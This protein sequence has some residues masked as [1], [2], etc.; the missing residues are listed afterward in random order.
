[1]EEISH[2]GGKSRFVIGY[3]NAFSSKKARLMEHLRDCPICGADLDWWFA[4]YQKGEQLSNE[5]VLPTGIEDRAQFLVALDQW[6]RQRKDVFEHDITRTL[7]YFEGSDGRVALVSI[8]DSLRAV[9]QGP[10]MPW[11]EAPHLWRAVDKLAQA[12]GD[13]TFQRILGVN[14]AR[15]QEWVRRQL[16]GSGHVLERT[17]SGILSCLSCSR[18]WPADTYPEDLLDDDCPVAPAPATLP[19]RLMGEVSEQTVANLLERLDKAMDAADNLPAQATLWITSS[20]GDETLA[21][22]FHEAVGVLRNLR[23]LRLHTVAAG[24]CSSAALLI[25][26]AGDKRSITPNTIVEIHQYQYPLSQEEAESAG[27]SPALPGETE[28]FD[29]LVAGIFAQATQNKITKETALMMMREGQ[30][31]TPEQCVELGIAH[32]IYNR[33]S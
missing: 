18:T 12:V 13:Q 1:M 29:A 14:Q 20:G 27:F 21:L 6:E 9:F 11:D 16:V 25:Y 31:L 7:E 30:V 17:E 33:E 26:L 24:Q 8:L 4:S 28:A 23:F 15:V 10:A 3:L 32:Q 2:P 5:A 19:L 22:G